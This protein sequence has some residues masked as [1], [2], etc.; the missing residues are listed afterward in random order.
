[1]KSPASSKCAGSLLAALAIASI[2]L[3]SACG[4]SN[5]PTPNQ[6]GFGNSNLTGTYV[7]SM[8]GWDVNSSSNAVPFAIAGII[9]ADG[10]G[11]IQSGTLDINDPGNLGVLPGEA[12][13]SANSGYS[14]SPDGRGTG[15]LA[16][17]AGTFNVDFVLATSSHG[18]ISRFDTLGTGSGTIDLQAA[19]PT[20]SGSYAFSLA[21]TDSGVNS[22]GT[23]GAFTISGTSISGI[24]E[25]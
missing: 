1:M 12:I 14:I 2:S 8:S 6:G 18:L 3:M 7:I 16:T 21:G 4:S 15:T 5:I 10:K 24:E 22:L 20:A 19:T 25:G 9:V 17:A 23:V 13:V 11:D